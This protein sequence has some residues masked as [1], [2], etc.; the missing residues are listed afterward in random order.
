MKIAGIIF[1]ALALPFADL[2]RE[3]DRANPM[4]IGSLVI[5]CITFW[6]DY[7]ENLV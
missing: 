2:S 5:A 1:L 3:Y 4:L 6:V 7:K